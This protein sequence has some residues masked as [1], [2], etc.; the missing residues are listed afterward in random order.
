MEKENKVRLAR[1]IVSAVLLAAAFVTDKFLSLPVWGSLLIYLIPYLVAGFDVLLEAGENILHLE[2]F[3]EDFLMAVATLGALAIGFLPDAKPQFAEAVFVMLFFQ[4][5]EFF[6]ELAEGRTRKSV[7]TLMDLQPTLTHIE[8]DGAVSDIEPENVE[9]GSI[10][11][12]KP[13]ERIPLD[14][15]VTEGKSSLDTRA[16]TGESAPVDVFENENVV[17]GCV[18]LSGLL[19]IKTTSLLGDSTAARILD[20]VENAADNK[21]K[22]ESFI[23]KFAHYYTPIVVFS[24]LAIAFIPPIIS[25]SFS[26]N[27]AKWLYRALTFLIVSCP[28]ALVVSVPLTFFGGIGKASEDGIL[29][30]GANYMDSL[31]S[32]STVVFDKTGTLTH[33]V[34]EVSDINSVSGNE[35]E[36]LFLAASAERYSVHPIAQSLSEAY[37]KYGDV[38]DAEVENVEEL[39]G[40]GVRADVNG[41]TVLAGN[42]KLMEKEGVDYA[43][44]DK[45]G[46]VVYVAADGEFL[47]FILISDTLKSDIRK[48]LESIKEEGV[49]K[50]V[51][52]TGDKRQISNEIA[53]TLGID[54]NYSELLP[55][56]KVEK[57]EKI[58]SE[59]T[60]GTVAF[61]GDGINDAPVLKRADIGVAMGVLGSQAAVEA[62]D[63]VLMDDNVSKIAKAISI[64]KRTIKIARQNIVFAI[65]VK[66]LVLIFSAVG[67]APLALAVFADVGVLVLAVINA[68]RAL[69]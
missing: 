10:I 7:T 57:M 2:L 12:V 16:L 54:E 53:E 36:L 9:I 32:L 6:E 46:T 45:S 28:C 69:K 42:M 11:I 26:L 29:I 13:G 4:V 30:K 18:N 50:T 35:K 44:C 68:M 19:K 48:A 59:R 1:I 20:L 49:V 47:G 61:V 23:T 25:G 33:G 43:A 62:A 41:K 58:L 21:S 15:V 8:R 27:I 24:A 67:L 51:M 52:L 5:G 14:G 3:D 37:S 34:F 31:A 60:Q 66:L 39:A 22:S 38:N 63:V 64:S 17:S 56:D 65:A 55:A 40:L